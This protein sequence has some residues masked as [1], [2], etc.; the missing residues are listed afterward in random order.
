[1]SDDELDRALASLIDAS[2][3]PGLHA[4]VMDRIAEDH[5]RGPKV[6]R[7]ELPKSARLVPA[8]RWQVALASA[9]VILIAAATWLAVR[10]GPAPQRVTT[11]PQRPDMTAPLSP[12]TETPGEQ[13]RVA[14]QPAPGR[15]EDRRV[16][17]QRVSAG[18]GARRLPEMTTPDAVADEASDQ[19][20][21]GIAPLIVL[22]IEEPAPVAIPPVVVNPIEIPQIQIPPVEDRLDKSS[23][24]PATG[25]EKKVSGGAS[26]APT[27]FRAE[28]A[29][30]LR[31]NRG[32]PT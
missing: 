16:G 21:P 11:G 27:E 18:L 32:E 14:V 10:P 17:S 24:P 9:A 7:S 20:V 19:A 23:Q 15:L 29:P 13:T 4:N 5:V 6:R 30:P 1:M 26:S 3:S 31:S 25:S 12:R 2:P 22:P 28:Q 8:V